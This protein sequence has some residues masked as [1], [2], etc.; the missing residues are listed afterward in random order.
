M[1]PKNNFD[2][3]R[4]YWAIGVLFLAAAVSMVAQCALG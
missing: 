4:L 2:P 3:R 1:Q